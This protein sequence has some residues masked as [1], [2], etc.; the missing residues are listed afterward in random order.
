MKQYGSIE[1]IFL[2]RSEVTGESKGYGF[3]E[4][5]NK[6]LA[7]QAKQSLMNT[8]SKYI[9][10]RILR[11]DFAE[12]NLT[13]CTYEGLHSK[14]LFID[15][16]PRD[17]TNGEVL[18]EIFSRTGTVT[19]AQVA[20]NH[21]TGASRGFAFVDY[22]TSIDAER[23][24]KAHNGAQI[25]GSN[26]R[27]A[28]GT[29]GRTGA[30]ILG[31]QPTNNVSQVV[32]QIPLIQ[33]GPADIRAMVPQWSAQPMPPSMPHPLMAR[34][35]MVHSPHIQ[36]I[37]VRGP[38]A[39]FPVPLIS[40][41]SP[42][43][44]CSQRAE[45]I[46]RPLIRE[47]GARM[48]SPPQRP[49][50]GGHLVRGPRPLMA[51]IPLRGPG[52]RQGGPRGFC[53]RGMAA[54]ADPRCAV[55]RNGP[56]RP[57]MDS[58]SNGNVFAQQPPEERVANQAFVPQMEQP[59]PGSMG[60]RPVNQSQPQRQQLQAL[61]QSQ[62]QPQ[63]LIQQ[64]QQQ[65]LMSPQNNPQQSQQMQQAPPQPLL[66]DFRPAE[67]QGP[68]VIAPQ[69]LLGQPIGGP[70][71]QM[72]RPVVHG[73]EASFD[74]HGQGQQAAPPGPMGL[75]GP[76]NGQWS[77]HQMSKPGSGPVP[78]QGLHQSPAKTFIPQP[79][80]EQ[81]LPGFP[82]GSTSLTAVTNQNQSG[83]W[84]TSQVTNGTQSIPS[85]TPGG[86]AV[87]LQYGL[88]PSQPMAPPQPLMQQLDQ[89]QPHLTSPQLSVAQGQ[90]V[91]PTQ[92]DPNIQY[93]N[94]GFQQQGPLVEQVGMP[95][96]AD[97]VQPPPPPQQQQPVGHAPQSQEIPQVVQLM[98]KPIQQPFHHHQLPGYPNQQGQVVQ[99]SQQMFQQ[100]PMVAAAET[101]WVQTAANVLQPTP[102]MSLQGF[103]VPSG[104]QEQQICDTSAQQ[105]RP[106]QQPTIQSQPGPGPGPG[107]LQQ[108]QHQMF[109]PT[110]Q[111]RTL[112]HSYQQ[113]QLQMPSNTST[114]S[115]IPQH[116]AAPVMYSTQA[117]SNDPNQHGQK[118]AN[119][120]QQLTDQS[121]LNQPQPL[122]QGMGE[123]YEANKRP[124]F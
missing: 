103:Q 61:M 62:V 123:F 2:V 94:Y 92:Q 78:Q 79:V 5:S 97:H 102:M 3:V 95:F 9:G 28:Y 19:F 71:G 17:F 110:Q 27:V 111:F 37:E 13:T 23:G 53:P 121:Y 1:R 89:T 31:L 115:P 58:N 83:G 69:P 38:A 114:P 81:M 29:P 22:A 15:K 20:V 116:S 118:R 57:L 47:A 119:P 106:V 56:A 40:Q 88:P 124:R 51:D 104:E 48:G 24:L 107:Q 21:Q 34:P 49:L 73:V 6:E 18:Q 105:W 30:S 50:I 77:E 113:Q 59:Q 120:D 36:N 35:L 7:A 42:A 108:E 85:Q 52:P 44:V 98:Q 60:I 26:I 8:G 64:Q 32:N 70:S 91:G 41:R 82:A 65:W 99:P 63:P 45:M 46:V 93:H 80:P 16:L 72:D 39:R 122:M 100:G 54:T 86:Q 55:F 90:A 12:P 74:R 25:E 101:K 67:A 33:A 117:S 87:P 84:Q 75:V 76:G 10:G 14:T 11:V 68:P 112:D 96:T 109:N 66:Q 43:Q 4:Y